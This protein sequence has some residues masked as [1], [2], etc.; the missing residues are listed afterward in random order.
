MSSQSVLLIHP[1]PDLE[2]V[3]DPTDRLMRIVPSGLQFVAEH[4][5]SS[6]LHAV[7]LSDVIIGLDRKSVV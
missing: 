4:L 6:G 1:P 5:R 3:L 2:E 7:I